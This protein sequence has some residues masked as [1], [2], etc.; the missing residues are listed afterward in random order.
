[1]CYMNEGPFA[2]YIIGNCVNIISNLPFVILVWN[3][4][5]SKNISE[6]FLLLRFFGGVMWIIYASLVYDL[7]MAFTNVIIVLSTSVI[8]YIKCKERIQSSPQTTSGSPVS[9]RTPVLSISPLSSVSEVLSE[10]SDHTITN[11]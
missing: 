10:P 6:T 7:L 11:I 9:T 1:M 3:N 2:I 4:R 8:Y 5:S